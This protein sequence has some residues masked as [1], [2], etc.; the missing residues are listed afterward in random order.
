[1]KVHGGGVTPWQDQGCAD[2][3]RGADGAED[4]DRTGALVMGGRGAG[5]PFRP[6]PGDLVLLADP[7]FVLKPNLYGCACR[8]RGA[9][10]RHSVWKV[11]L[12]APAAAGSW[13]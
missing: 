3:A 5:S 8:E 1:M 13:A 12:N 7:G 11:F 2:A 10:F 6:A 4:I 9:D